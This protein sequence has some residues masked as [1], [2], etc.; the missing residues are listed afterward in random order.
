MRV[1]RHFLFF[2]LGA[3]LLAG[4]FGA[5][6]LLA[7][8]A[9]DL[10]SI[11]FYDKYDRAVTLDDFRGK[12]VLVNIWATWCPPCLLEL[13]SLN[14]LPALLP[15]DKFAV[16]AISLDSAPQPGFLAQ[17]KAGNLAFYWDKNREISLK[18]PAKGL[19]TSYLLD[20]TGRI[21][22]TFDGAYDWSA[23]VV[24]DK[25]KEAVHGPS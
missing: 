23:P 1:K 11:V 4:G 21:I 5:G 6:R 24:F 2:L 9:G 16:V 7:P 13:P 22:A 19:P 12:I 3:A 25:I 8:P 18:W 15:A 14:K 10:P 17:R 20:G